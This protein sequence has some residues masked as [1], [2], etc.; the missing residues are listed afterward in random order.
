VKYKWTNDDIDTNS[1]SDL[2]VGIK[3]QPAKYPRDCPTTSK[4]I[5]GRPFLTKFRTTFRAGADGSRQIAVERVGTTQYRNEK[6]KFFSYT[7]LLLVVIVLFYSI[8][9]II[10]IRSAGHGHHDGHGHEKGGHHEQHGDLEHHEEGDD[11]KENHNSESSHRHHDEVHTSEEA[12][13]RNVHI[14]KEDV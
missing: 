12:K 9:C 11:H 1:I 6:P 5:F 2:W 8:G 14:D 7:L 13:H 10:T 3:G 4:I